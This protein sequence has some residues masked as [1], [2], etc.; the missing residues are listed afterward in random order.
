MPITFS[1]DDH[2]RIIVTNLSGKVTDDELVEYYDELYR[3][4]RFLNGANE[5]LTTEGLLEIDV[6]TNTMMHVTQLTRELSAR[7]P[8]KKI[9]LVPRTQLEYGYA[10]MYEL[11]TD[12]SGWDRRLFESVDEAVAWLQTS[13]LS[14]TVTT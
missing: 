11:L 5:L 4:E 14:P 7:L 6:H 9:A 2:R 12:G 1:Y 3:N 8:G 13:T 10:R